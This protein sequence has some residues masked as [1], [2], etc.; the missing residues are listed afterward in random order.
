MHRVNRTLAIVAPVA[1][2]FA[3]ARLAQVPQGGRGGA[4]AGPSLMQAAPKPLVPDA[5]PVRTCESL[6]SVALPN[7][8]IESAQF[9]CSAPAQN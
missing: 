9:T 5:K 7:T 1:V 6:A 2:V 4:P 8:T 3:T